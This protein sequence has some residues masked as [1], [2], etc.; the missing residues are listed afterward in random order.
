MLYLILLAAAPELTLSTGRDK[1]GAFV[2]AGRDSTQQLVATL[3]GDATRT[4]RY[5]V[6]PDGVVKVDATGLVAPVKEGKAVITATVG[7]ASAKL[8][9]TVTNIETDLP[10]SFANEI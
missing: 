4:A 9:V 6:S 3:G 8:G 7:G 2:L 5:T 10:V 1:D